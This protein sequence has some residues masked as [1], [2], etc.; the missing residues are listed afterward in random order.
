MWG[1]L[2]PP[3]INWPNTL[4]SLLAHNQVAIFVGAG[5][6]ATAHREGSK[7]GLPGW[8]KMISKMLEDNKS[9]MPSDIVQFIE[10]TNNH[11]HYFLSMQ[12]LQ[13]YT[14]S[15]ADYYSSVRALIAGKGWAPSKAHQV[16]SSLNARV[17]LTTNFDHILDDVLKEKN[18]ADML[19]YTEVGPIVDHLRSGQNI[20][21][22]VHGD[23]SDS[24]HLIFTEGEYFAS[25]RNQSLFYDVLSSIFLNYTVLFLGY[26]AQDPDIGFVLSQPMLHLAEAS[27]NYILLSDKQADPI[28]KKRFKDNYNI[29]VITY[30]AKDIHDYSKF[31]PSL[32]ELNNRAFQEA[33]STGSDLGI[34]K[35]F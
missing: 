18:E 8:G 34:L 17:Y 30:T 20:L 14:P 35:E 25:L 19:K 16:I 22:K 9:S 11:G 26:S 3:M 29:T 2:V 13:M 12:A 7:D 15:I 32:I 10:K 27:P 33:Q 21:I 4:I 23:P 24:K 31:I 5:V 28:T 6:S 1:K